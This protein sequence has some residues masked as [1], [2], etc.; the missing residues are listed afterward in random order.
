MRRGG[1]TGSARSVTDAATITGADRQAW[2][3]G[4][5]R[6]QGR[7]RLRDS[8]LGAL[9][10]RRQ[11]RAI[12]HTLCQLGGMRRRDVDTSRGQVGLNQCW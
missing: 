12:S 3:R 5:R 9:T 6:S 10:G 4:R 2:N 11:V 1:S 8:S 7:G